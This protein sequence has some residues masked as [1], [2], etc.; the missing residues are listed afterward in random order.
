MF[1]SIWNQAELP[2]P[3]CSVPLKPMFEP[4]MFDLGRFTPLANAGF[5]LR[6]EQGTDVAYTARALRQSQSRHSKEDLL[7][8]LYFF[9]S[10]TSLRFMSDRA[11]PRV[12]VLD[13]PVLPLEDALI[14]T[15]LSSNLKD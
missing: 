4:R 5:N 2:P 6:D 9:S 10:I 11:T 7:E 12:D 8:P 13:L 14:L 3:S 1:C 15:D